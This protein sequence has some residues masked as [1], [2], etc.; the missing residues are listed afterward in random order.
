MKNI[1][2]IKLFVLTSYISFSQFWD[3]TTPTK[4]GGTVNTEFDEIL[5]IFSSD[6]ST[7]FFTRSF[8]PENIGGVNDQDIWFSKKDKDGMYTSCSPLSSLNSKYNNGVF[9]I[10]KS[11]TA[12]YLIDAYEGK[13]DQK[14]GCAVATGKNGLW[15]KPSHLD[16]TNLDI[17]GDAY[18]FHINS[19]EDVLIISYKGTSTLGEEDLYVSKKMNGVW[20]QAVHMGKQINTSGFE[21]SPFLSKNSDTLFFSSNG[22]GGLGDADVF[23]SVRQDESYTNWSTPVNLGN[24]INSPKFDAYFSYNETT[25]FLAS[26]RDGVNSDIYTSKILFPDP[27]TGTLV[28]KNVSIYQGKDGKVDITIKGGVAPYTYKW[29]NGNSMEDLVNVPKGDYTVIV[30]DMKGKTVELKASLTEPV[31]KVG[32]DIAT[33]IDLNPI[34]YNSGKWDLRKDATIEL[35]KVIKVMNEHP[36]MV[37]ELGSHTDCK[38]AVKFNKDLSQKRANAAVAYIQKSITNPK[39]IYGKGYGESKLKVN[40]PCEGKVKSTCPEEEHAKNRRT[41]FLIISMGK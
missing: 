25:I 35:D 15:S 28:S 14:K 33:L 24:K 40:C 5:P 2:I 17:D 19:K 7:L 21:I 1:F 29:S 41:E 27:L 13:K 9:G 11:G 8:S 36:S 12:I 10:N 3:V 23:Y 37:V 39:R 34:Y 20:Q 26:N 38:S 4:L 31:L 18:G 22:L 16:I 30:T 6:S 32:T